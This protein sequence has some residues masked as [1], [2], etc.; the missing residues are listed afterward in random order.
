M[1]S[2]FVSV[3]VVKIGEVLLS[4]S[5]RELKARIVCPSKEEKSVTEASVAKTKDVLKTHKTGIVTRY[6]IVLNSNID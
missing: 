5:E 4:K 3:T 6:G 1:D 2:K